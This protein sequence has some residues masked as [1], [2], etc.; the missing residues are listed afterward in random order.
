[1]H[2][3]DDGIIGGYM[4][5]IWAIHNE[6]NLIHLTVLFIAYAFR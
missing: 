6:I 2:G 5:V 1:M 3:V 4:M